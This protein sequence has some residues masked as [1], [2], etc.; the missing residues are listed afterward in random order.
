[1][2]IIRINIINTFILYVLDIINLY[3]FSNMIGLNLSSLTLTNP[4]MQCKKGQRE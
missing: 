3:S 1:M 4:G 2:D